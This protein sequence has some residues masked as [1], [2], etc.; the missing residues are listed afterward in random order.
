METTP[1]GVIVGLFQ[2]ISQKLPPFMDWDSHKHHHLL[3]SNADVCNTM[4]EVRQHVTQYGKSQIFLCG[5]IWLIPFQSRTFEVVRNQFLTVTISTVCLI[6]SCLNSLSAPTRRFRNP[7]HFMYFCL[8]F[9]NHL[10][11]HRDDRNEN[12][13]TSTRQTQ[14]PMTYT[15]FE[16]RLFFSYGVL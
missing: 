8:Q 4:T 2:A 16:T 3:N 14:R 6:N 7:H 1:V 12:M 15:L 10:R 9:P 5:G 13:F 11:Q